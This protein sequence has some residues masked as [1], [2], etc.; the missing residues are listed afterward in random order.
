MRVRVCVWVSA[1]V[2]ECG[3][4]VCVRECGVFVCVRE[5]VCVDV[6]VCACVP[7]VGA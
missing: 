1:C 7:R 4:F 5:C 2:R 3:V 6:R